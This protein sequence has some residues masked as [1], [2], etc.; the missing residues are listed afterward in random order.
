MRWSV[1]A[2]RPAGSALPVGWKRQTVQAGHSQRNKA[3]L[4][5]RVNIVVPSPFRPNLNKHNRRSGHFTCVCKLICWKCTCRGVDEVYTLMVLYRN[6]M[7]IT[8]LLQSSAVVMVMQRVRQVSMRLTRASGLNT[9]ISCLQYR[10]QMVWLRVQI[11][12]TCRR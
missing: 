8:C 5:R 2:L 12:Q 7:N 10:R 1:K 4:I 3:L 11:V 6:M 9:V